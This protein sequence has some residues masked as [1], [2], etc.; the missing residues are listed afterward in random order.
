MK[1]LGIFLIPPGWDANPYQHYP[2][3][4]LYF[5]DI[6]LACVTAASPQKKIGEGWL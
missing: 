4:K 6:H 2:N 5:V 1:Q 3:I